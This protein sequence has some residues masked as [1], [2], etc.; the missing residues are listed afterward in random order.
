MYNDPLEVMSQAN[1]NASQ[2]SNRGSTP[3]H[4]I[5][6]NISNNPAQNEN[7]AL[8]IIMN[9]QQYLYLFEELMS[10]I[11]YGQYQHRIEFIL[12]VL[13][14]LYGLEISI[15][16]LNI[17]D[18][19]RN[20]DFSEN[21]IIILS[22]FIFFGFSVGSIF[23]KILWN[24][25]GY[26]RSLLTTL[27]L[28]MVI[29]LMSVYPFTT[30]DFIIFR[31]ICA[32][33]MNLLKNFG[34]N[35]LI[36]FSFPMRPV[37]ELYFNYY[38]YYIIGQSIS[39]AFTMIL[40]DYEKNLILSDYYQLLIKLSLVICFITYLL[41][42]QYVM[43]SIKYSLYWNRYQEGFDTFNQLANINRKNMHQQD[44]LDDFKKTSLTYWTELYIIQMEAQS[45][46]SIIKKFKNI[47]NNTDDTQKIFAFLLIINSMIITLSFYSFPLVVT[48]FELSYERKFIEFSESNQI[49]V[50]C[51]LFINYF[52]QYIGFIGAEII[53]KLPSLNKISIVLIGNCLIIIFSILIYSCE[54]ANGGFLW[55]FSI[56]NAFL[57][58]NNN[59][60][61]G[62]FFNRD[63]K[64]T[65]KEVIKFMENITFLLV[66]FVFWSNLLFSYNY[67]FILYGALYILN[68]FI[69][70][71]LYFYEKW[72]V[73]I[74]R[75]IHEQP[76]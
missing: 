7:I 65:A 10:D 8:N 48:L 28:Y 13:M 60:M 64:E 1:S 63:I 32:I 73:Q 54:G 29:S 56:L 38:C 46:I 17:T 6:I 69:V 70:L 49:N 18:F 59:E 2:I 37:Q 26:K 21:L 43:E 71:G 33:L 72:R 61:K 41:I 50:W 36:E 53:R 58:S 39:C 30:L 20:Q 75:L 14:F 67:I 55:V 23:S 47:Y 44:Y 42:R 68:L 9:R 4:E 22:S 15:I 40:D 5:D 19:L 62:Y 57:F 35:L 31:T 51:V 66:P 34:Y 45:N 27:T 76:Q 24:R 74:D 25:F 16:A 11:G 12:G 3:V 52:V